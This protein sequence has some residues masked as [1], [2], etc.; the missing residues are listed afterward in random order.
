MKTL[1]TTKAISRGEPSGTIQAPDRLLNV[2]LC[3]VMLCVALIGC[4]GYVDRGYGATVV[5]PAPAIPVPVPN[6]GVQES[7]P[8]CLRYP[9]R[10]ISSTQV[11]LRGLMAW[12]T[13]A[14]ALQS[15]STIKTNTQ[16]ALPPR[17]LSSWVRVKGSIS[18]EETWGWI[19]E[20]DIEEWPGPSTHSKILLVHPPAEEKQKFDRLKAE[21]KK[22][23]ETQAS[24]N[25]AA[26]ANQEIVDEASSK[27]AAIDNIGST[28]PLLTYLVQEDELG[29]SRA[30][31]NASDQKKIM[32]TKSSAASG[33]AS[34][35][36]HEL[37][38]MSE[39]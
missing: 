17:P 11:D 2:T 9:Q 20:A 5:V 13:N 28:S 26:D 37:E 27:A 32:L 33:A 23:Q 18:S 16:Q 21:S 29:Y 4:V 39:G 15:R 31:E 6:V 7:T 25:S 30:A 3:R 36:N 38:E 35:A 12:W 22:D 34:K 24:A 19:V 8:Y 1:F 14:Q 10:M